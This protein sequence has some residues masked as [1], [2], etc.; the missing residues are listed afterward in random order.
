[1]HLIPWFR[2]V[3]LAGCLAFAP[4]LLA[5][6]RP[7]IGFVYPA[8]GQQGTTVRLRLGGQNL[9]GV[10]AAL[11]TGSGVTA[12]GIELHRRLNNQEVQLLREQLRQLKQNPTRPARSASSSLTPENAMMTSPADDEH[13]AREPAKEETTWI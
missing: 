3:A 1:M 2:R 13:T 6:P 7:Y 12:R 9:D 11:V 4:A 10:H 8:G 5:Q